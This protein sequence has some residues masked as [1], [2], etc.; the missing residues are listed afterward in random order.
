MTYKDKIAL[1]TSYPEG[2]G[3]FRF[4]E[5]AFNLG[6]YLNLIYFKS[7]NHKLEGTGKTNLE[8]T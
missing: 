1:V 5:N 7:I 2:T 4:V 6:Y 8:I 3:V